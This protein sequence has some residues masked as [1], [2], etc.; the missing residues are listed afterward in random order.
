MLSHKLVVAGFLLL[1]GLALG[2]GNIWVVAARSTIP[3]ALNAEVIEV[4][5]RHEKHPGKDDVCLLHFATGEALHVDASVFKKIRAGDFVRKLPWSFEIVVNDEST[6]LMWSA[7][8]YGMI[9]AMPTI[10]IALIATG[11][12]ACRAPSASA[13]DHSRG[14]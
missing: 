13:T 11:F 1:L 4:E 8:F 3:L 6:P 12:F 10:L 7:D 14:Q 2:C 5:L 9:A